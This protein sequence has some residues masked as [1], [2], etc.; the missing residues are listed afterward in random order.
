MLNVPLIRRTKKNNFEDEQ[1]HV[2]SQ[3]IVKPESSLTICT[4]RRISIPVYLL[5]GQIQHLAIRMHFR[6]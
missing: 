5:C 1:K 3:I 2:Q 6:G 4:P